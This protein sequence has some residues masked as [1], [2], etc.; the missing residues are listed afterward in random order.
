MADVSVPVR[1]SAIRRL[2]CGA[3]SSP[4][5]R[6]AAGSELIVGF[7]HQRLAFEGEFRFRP[8]DQP[9]DIGAV[10]ENDEERHK[11]GHKRITERHMYV[12]HPGLR[13]Q[14]NHDRQR[15]RTADRT[16]RNVLRRD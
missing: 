7:L 2:R 1:T 8:L 13:K 14:V 3:V 4:A 15:Q 6:F 11:R 10:F 5:D 16:E 9:H 12:R